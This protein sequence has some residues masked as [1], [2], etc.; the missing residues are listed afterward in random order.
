MFSINA[1]MLLSL[2]T[3]QITFQNVYFL[4]YPSPKDV[5]YQSSAQPFLVLGML[6]TGLELGRTGV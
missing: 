3:P 1:A 2:I 5:K 6:V 4:I